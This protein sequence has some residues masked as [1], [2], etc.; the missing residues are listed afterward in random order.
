MGSS[1]PSAAAALP[2]VRKAG[3]SARRPRASTTTVGSEGS[4]GDGRSSLRR[5]RDAVADR[6][7]GHLVLNARRSKGPAFCYVRAHGDD[8]SARA[9]RHCEVERAIAPTVDDITRHRRHP[10][11]PHQRRGIVRVHG[12]GSLGSRERPARFVGFDQH[13]NPR[14]GH[15][16]R[17]CGELADRAAADDYDEVPCLGASARSR[18]SLWRGCHPSAGC[19]RCTLFRQLA[20]GLVGKR[21]P[22]VL[23]LRSGEAGTECGARA[24][25]GPLSTAS[26][27]L[28]RTSGTGRRQ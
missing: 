6:E 24:E 16:R 1:L 28:D 13:D 19:F 10:S 18:P 7:A 11:F 25:E 9:Q 15:L 27:R 5:T 20:Q 8:A 12:D 2:A 17:Q 14:T 26:V 21:H 22:D 3:A 4:A 23:R